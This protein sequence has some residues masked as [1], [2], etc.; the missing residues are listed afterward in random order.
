MSESSQP[1]LTDIAYQ[2]GQ[3]TQQIAQGNAQSAVSPFRTSFVRAALYRYPRDSD[4]W[5]MADC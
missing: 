2:L 3:I 1:T 5:T 4:G